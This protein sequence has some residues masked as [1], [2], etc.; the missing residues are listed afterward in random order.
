MPCVPEMDGG[1]P[2]RQKFKRYPIGFF[3][4]DIAEVRTGE[5]K[6]HLFV[7]IGRTSK[8]AVAPMVGKANR[9]TA[10]GFLELLLETVPYRLHT[11]LAERANECAT[12]SIAASGQQF[13]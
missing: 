8:F 6:L 3:R 1:A 4:I 5:G 13:E 11:I 10:W 2:K 9:K 12:G 7:A